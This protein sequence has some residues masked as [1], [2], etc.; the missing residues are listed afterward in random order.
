VRFRKIRRTHLV[1]VALLAIRLGAVSPAL[2][3]A[4]PQTGSLPIEV[5]DAYQRGLFAL[6]ARPSPLSTSAAQTVWRIPII[7]VQFP[8]KALTYSAADFKTGIFDTT[9]STLTGSVFDY[10]QWA[11]GGRLRVVGDVVATV[12]LPG[13]RTYYGNQSWGLSTTTTPNNIYGMVHD[14]L[15]LSTSQVDWSLYDMDHDG[16]VDML[17]IVHA[18]IGGEGSPDRNNAWS[19][20]SRM[21][22][23]WRTGAAFLTNQLIPGTSSQFYRLDRFSTLPELSTVHLGKRSEIGVYCHEFGHALGLPDL[24]DTSNLAAVSNIGPGN[25]S[26]MS[27]GGRGGDGASPQYPSHLGGWC[28]LFLGWN[29]TFRPT[30]DTTLVIPPLER[31]GPVVELWF[32]GESYPEHFLIENRQRDGFDRNLPNA[33]LI[34]THVDEAAIGQRIGG[35]KINVGTTPGMWLLEADGDSDLVVG[36]NRGDANDPFPGALDRIAIDDLSSPNTRTFSGAVTNLGLSDILRTNL[37]VQAHLQVLAPG[38]LPATDQTLD[39]FSPAGFSGPAHRAVIE[40]DGTIDVVH[41]EMRGSYPQIVLRSKRRSG[42][43]PPLQLSASPE[44]ALDPAIASLPDGNLAIVWSDTRGGRAR[45]LYRS[46]LQGVWNGEQILADVPGDNR[47]PAMGADAHGRVEVAWL[48]VSGDVPRLYFM[49]FLYFAPFGQPIAVTAPEEIPGRPALEVSREGVGYLLWPDASLSPQRYLFSRF[50]PDSGL[51]PLHLPL[52]PG[53]ANPQTAISAVVDSAGTL[54]SLWQ[55]SGAGIS[56]LHYQERWKSAHPAPRDTT[57]E[58]RGAPISDA[59]IAAD[60][61]GSLHVAFAATSASGQQI[62]YKR[63]RAGLGWDFRST[64]VSSPL[65]GSAASPM[66]APSTPG[67]V[68]LLYAA[69]PAGSARFI[70]RLRRLDGADPV[71]VT[72]VAIAPRPVL[73]LGPNPLRS[74]AALEFRW[75]GAAPAAVPT[76]DIFDLAGR[77]VASVPLDDAA[78]IWRGR[79][80]SSTTAGW[81]SGVYFAKLKGERGGNARLVLLR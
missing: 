32:Q 77:R 55:V 43:Q 70:E 15:S 29:P 46:R 23:G 41:S 38:W 6:P 31:G 52:T 10:Y 42:W 37:D 54:H 48:N 71:A 65:D 26:L 81:A 22:G 30:T 60:P 72:P 78:G 16:Y 45:I 73:E 4:P 79:L 21:S 47:A 40:P 1:L 14:A 75:R 59:V 19:I 63:W 33:G 44:A 67:N 34:I 7:L 9:G 12:Q 58:L 69:Y 49:R 74:G 28:S 80:G 76:V 56:E 5:A 3:T 62:Y 24:Y 11:S 50:H 36:R 61:L 64:Q 13:D 51:S 57:V 27:T 2:A 8:D 39:G 35:N 53:T 17:W 66:L 18:G 20:T 68:T 25:W